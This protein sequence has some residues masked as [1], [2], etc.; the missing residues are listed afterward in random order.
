MRSE[1]Y[2]NE[3]GV[4]TIGMRSCNMASTVKNKRFPALS[5]GKLVRKT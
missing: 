2:W 3:G 5:S 4:R 1:D